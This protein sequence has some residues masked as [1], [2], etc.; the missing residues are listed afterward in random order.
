MPGVADV[1]QAVVAPPAVGM[2]HAV[3]SHPATKSIETGS[4]PVSILPFRYS[5]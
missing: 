4:A 1:D 2:D 5:D 3:Q